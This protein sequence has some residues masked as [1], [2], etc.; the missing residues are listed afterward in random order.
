M[1]QYQA[2]KEAHPDALLFFRMGDF[3]ELFYEDAL[4][5]SRELQLTL[6]SRDKARQVPMCG[7]PYHAGAT[8]L[9]KLLRKGYKVALCEQM[10]DPK[11]AKTVVRREVT[12]VLTP[13]TALND[14]L[15]AGESQWLAALAPL[16]NSIGI[17]SLD[18]STGDLRATEFTGPDAWPQ[19]F[20]E[21]A[22]MKPAETLLPKGNAL[23]NAAKAQIPL[24]TSP[25]TPTPSQPGAPSSTTA[26]P[27][28]KVGLETE[29]ATPHLEG[30]K[31]ELDDFVFT[32]DYALPLLRQS[33]R[34][35]S[36]D[37]MGLTH[38]PAAATA[39]GALVH[40]LRATKQ[41]ALEH[42]DTVHFY[43][44]RTCL[45]LDAVSIRNL[46]L[47][48]PLFSGETNE[49]TLLHTLDACCTPMG[50]RLLRA[51]L[52]R[53]LINLHRHQPTPRRRS[54]SRQQTS[55]AAKPSAAP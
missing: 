6:T 32:P 48:D 10:E 25:Q 34:V 47:V 12:R 53:P 2:A 45:E 40:Y 31:T 43:E 8:Y 42:L 27:S 17:A 41:G 21:L 35:H 46:E 14:T 55:A 39:A 1:R 19:A 23:G 49:T 54:L 4:I 7:V 51:Q 20:D 26:S 38:H 15:P 11:L 18:L 5:A 22:R 13:G 29:D 37:G 28:S 36:L 50:K 44:R 52:L 24:D 3:Y 16:S 33:L 30:P 9:Q